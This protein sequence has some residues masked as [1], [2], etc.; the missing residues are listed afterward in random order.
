MHDNPLS[1]WPIYPGSLRKLFIRAFTAGLHDPD[2]RVMEN[3]WRKEMCALRDAIFLCPQCGAENFFD[4]EL[5]RQKKGL[6]PCWG[7]RS[8]LRNPPRLRMGSAYGSQLVMLSPG[9]QLFAHHLEGDT[10]NFESPL[11]EVVTKPLGLKNLSPVR[12]TSR[13]Q[14]GSTIEVKPNEVL[15]LAVDCHIHFGKTEAEVR[16]N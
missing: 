3:E 8:Q 6:E 4:L 5:L 14:N 9:A 2:A 15:P 12:W 1:F 16:V 11:A 13:T 10:Y 7:C